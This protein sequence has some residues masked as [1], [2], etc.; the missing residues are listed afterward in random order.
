MGCKYGL[1]MFNIVQVEC[2]NAE[3]KIKKQQ[4]VRSIV[5]K[6]PNRKFDTGISFTTV[7]IYEISYN[8]FPIVTNSH[9]MFYHKYSLLYD[10]D[11]DASL[12]MN[13]YVIYMYS[14]INHL[15]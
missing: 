15:Y 3:K 9:K 13:I 1:C 7:K 4:K 11:K 10:K 6:N 14:N 8:H 5:H 2:R 12:C